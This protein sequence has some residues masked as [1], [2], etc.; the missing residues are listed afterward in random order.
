MI[1][2]KRT[3]QLLVVGK[4]NNSQNKN[5]DKFF[6]YDIVY[7]IWCVKYFENE[8]ILNLKEEFQICYDDE[9]NIIYLIGGRT[10]YKK[11][12]NNNIIDFY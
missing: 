11:K 8:K 3:K 5:E 2:V 1:F 6:I 12:N 9:R 4:K 10:E 7:K